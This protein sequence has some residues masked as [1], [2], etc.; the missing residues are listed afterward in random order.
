MQSEGGW[1]NYLDFL[2]LKTELVSKETSTL[3][4][5]FKSG[6][7]GLLGGLLEHFDK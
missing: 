6:F 4:N 2:S 5:C 1:G 3:I 7:K